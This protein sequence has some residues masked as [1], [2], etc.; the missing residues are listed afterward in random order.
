M[1]SF[2]YSILLTIPFYTLQAQECFI[3]GTIKGIGNDTLSIFLYP[4][5][6]G[7]DYIHEKVICKDDS[8]DFHAKLK[9]SMVHMAKIYKESWQYPDTLPFKLYDKQITFSVSPGDSLTFNAKFEG[10]GIRYEVFGSNLS[11]QEN[12]Y[13]RDVYSLKNNYN[14]HG[15]NYISALERN[16]SIIMNAELMAINRLSEKI[17]QKSIK[18][19][20]L[21][22]DWEYSANLLLTMP[23]DSCLKYYEDLGSNAKASFFGQYLKDYL[24]MFKLK[25]GAAAPQFSLPDKNGKLISLTDFKG[26]YVVLDFWGTWCSWCMREIP[27]MKNYYDKYSEKVEFIGIACKDQ[28]SSWEKVLVEK[29]LN[30]TNLFNENKEL[31]KIYGIR[32]YPSKVIINPEGIIIDKFLGADADFFVKLDELFKE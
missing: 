3:S 28:M 25:T 20:L 26:K 17:T 29:D 31:T 6:T 21:H 2:I 16:D 19:V 12:A 14:L 8:F 11:E 30:W 13:Q 4:L 1:R 9:L 15:F 23:L 24:M 32:G 10:Y 5:K 22:P 7:E 27:R 18:Y